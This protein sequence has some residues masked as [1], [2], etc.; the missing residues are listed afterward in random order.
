MLTN[1][2]LGATILPYQGAFY[3]TPDGE[4]DRQKVNQWIRTS[5]QFDAV[6]DRRGDA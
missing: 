2:R 6:I 3:F 4:A 1:P 5:G